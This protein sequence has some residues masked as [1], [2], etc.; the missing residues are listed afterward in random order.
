MGPTTAMEHLAAGRILDAHDFYCADSRCRDK[1][2]RVMLAGLA[3]DSAVLPYFKTCTARAC[4]TKMGYGPDD[5]P[6]ADD[7]HVRGCGIYES[8]S[9]GSREDVYERVV[10]DMVVKLKSGTPLR[11]R[12]VRENQEA[13][14]TASP[15]TGEVRAERKNSKLFGLIDALG[16]WP[17]DSLRSRRVILRNDERTIDDL[18][19]Q[20][21]I[22]D[23]V[24]FMNDFKPVRRDLARG[25]ISDETETTRIYFG[26]ATAS[27]VA[28]DAVRIA[29]TGGIDLG[30]AFEPPSGTGS[31]ALSLFLDTKML[32]VSRNKEMLLEDIHRLGVGSAQ[33]VP[34]FIFV[35]GKLKRLYRLQYFN[36]AALG[37]AE[38]VVILTRSQGARFQHLVRHLR[39]SKNAAEA[40]RKAAVRSRADE[41][42]RLAEQRA[43]ALESRR[44]QVA[45]PSAP[46]K[47]QPSVAN[48]RTAAPQASR[49]GRESLGAR[50]MRWL[51]NDGDD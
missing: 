15:T 29:F 17:E 30:L 16:G 3:D 39:A 43:R 48:V 21:S 20:A 6:K 26:P 40:V 45:V 46:V 44:V 37:T 10:G 41:D 8:S 32:N 7:M 25:V 36:V 27:I 31:V 24:A 1:G 42:A 23:D 11:T 33:S 12:V 14:R 34:C 19:V 38:D 35:L 9:A 2:V 13:V 47:A 5:K 18:F 4:L 22:L 50:F 51:R 28:N 49:K